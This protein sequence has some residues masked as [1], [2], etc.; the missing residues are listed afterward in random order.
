MLPLQEALVVLAEAEEARR[1]A[2]GELQTVLG[3]LGLRQGAGP[4]VGATTTDSP[5]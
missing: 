3:R 2:D 4:D 1:E 5:K